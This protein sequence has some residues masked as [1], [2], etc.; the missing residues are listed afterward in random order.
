[1]PSQLSLLLSQARRLHIIHILKQLFNT[2]QFL[3]SMFF[4]QPNNLLLN[5]LPQLLVL[6]VRGFLLAGGFEVGCQPCDRIVFGLPGVSLF[7]LAVEGGVVRGGVVGDSVGHVL[8]EE[9]LFGLHYLLPGE[10]GRQH[11]RECVIAV[12][13]HGPHSVAECKFGYP[14]ALELLAIV[15]GDG[16]VVVPA[17]EKGLCSQ[18]DCEVHGCVEIAFRG[19]A[20][21]EEWERDPVRV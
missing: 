13:P 21:A 3:P 18:G 6:S 9:G 15:R 20:L 7:V 5:T 11:H 14:V 16:I 1:M 19:G 17:G 10:P 2:R 12:H 8:D 4:Q